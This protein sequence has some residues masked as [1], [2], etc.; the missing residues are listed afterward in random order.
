MSTLRFK[1]IN[2]KSF[3]FLG[4]FLTLISTILLVFSAVAIFVFHGRYHVGIDQHSILIVQETGIL[5]LYG[6]WVTFVPVLVFGIYGLYMAFRGNRSDYFDRT[7]IKPLGYLVIAGF[8]LMLAGRVVGQIV[9]I[10]TFESAGYQK[11]ENSYGLT[12]N[13][14]NQVWVTHPEICLDSTVRSMLR[15]H[16]YSADDVN[17]HISQYH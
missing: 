13:W 8:I 3:L 15:S 2:R 16:R 7:F 12:G 11:C 17:G 4:L 1:K 5:Y 9:W 10:E 14:T 6:G